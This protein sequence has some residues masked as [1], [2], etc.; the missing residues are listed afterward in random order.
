M[1]A[2]ISPSCP[3]CSSRVTRMPFRASAIAAVR[4]PIP[5]PTTMARRAFTYGA[6]SGGRELH[7]RLRLT[8]EPREL[9]VGE[10]QEVMV[11]FRRPPHL[12]LRRVV[13]RLWY[14]TAAP[15]ARGR[16]PVTLELVRRDPGEPDDL[17]IDPRA[18]VDRLGRSRELERQSFRPGEVDRL[19]EAVVDRTEDD[20]AMG[21]GPLA[22]RPQISP[23]DDG[24]SE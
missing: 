5:P 7:R 23:G 4:P 20:D 8:H 6:R 3:A 9:V 24:Q 18:T 2:P 13:G 10:R 21:A 16:F 11:L 17:R 19:A 1:P 14:C 15:C 22:G 12:R